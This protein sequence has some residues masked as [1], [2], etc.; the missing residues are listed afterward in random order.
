MNI[1]NEYIHI[2]IFQIYTY[3]HLLKF[4]YLYMIIFIHLYTRTGM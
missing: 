2:Y 1:D 3:I 4:I